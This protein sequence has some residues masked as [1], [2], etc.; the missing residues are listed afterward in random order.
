M[1]E[2]QA[3]KLMGECNNIFDE[4]IKKFFI[5][6]DKLQIEGFHTKRGLNGDIVGVVAKIGAQ[7]QR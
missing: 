2:K 6:F 3:T 4:F 7:A 1:T 5:K